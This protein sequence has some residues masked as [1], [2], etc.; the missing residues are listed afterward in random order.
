MGRSSALAGF[1]LATVM[2]VGCTYSID[3]NGVR[4]EG[5]LVRESREVGD[6]NA[7]D[8]GGGIHVRMS[9]GQPATVELEAEQNILDI[10]TV[11][12]R[13]GVLTI[14]ND[15]SYSS[16]RGVTLTIVAPEFT[17]IVLSGGADGRLDGLDASGLSVDVSGGADLQA[18]G[19]VGQLDVV[20]SGGAKAHL[21]GLDAES[22]QL[23]ASG[24]AT[25]E[26]SASQR[27]EG[28]ASGGA[29]VHTS[30]DASVDVSTSGGASVN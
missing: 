29:T 27:I 3:F 12:V 13:D 18:E 11:T 25:V 19:Q 16:P 14:D 17:E 22:V 30:G 26:V 7:I 28:S 23:D 2:V 8:V 20:A 15:E 10:L 1:G 9:I 5:P 21:G 4:G 24:G 6:F